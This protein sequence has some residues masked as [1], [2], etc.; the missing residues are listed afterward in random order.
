[1]LISVGDT[2]EG[3]AIASRQPVLVGPRVDLNRFSSPWVRHAVENGVR[4][5]CAV[6][7]IT[8][9]RTLGAL[10]VVSTREDAFT[11]ADAELLSKCAGS[12]IAIA[13][14]NALNF[15]RAHQAEDEMRRQFERERLLLEINNAVVSHLDLPELLGTVSACLK[16]VLPHDLAGIALY[17]PGTH[18]LV[19]HA[20]DFPQAIK[21]SSRWALRFRSTELP[22]V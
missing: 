18:R 12:Q 19:A 17:D 13:V 11:A 21:T 1:M 8:H 2:P 5:G 15:A 9:N 6:P 7:L 4:S 10:S 20:L 3:Q 22:K 14:A 16:R